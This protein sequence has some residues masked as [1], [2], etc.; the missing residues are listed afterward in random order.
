MTSWISLSSFL[1]ALITQPTFSPTPPLPPPLKTWMTLTWQLLS[2]SQ[3]NAIVTYLCRILCEGHQLVSWLSNYL[4][5]S[6]FHPAFL[7][8]FRLLSIFST[9]LLLSVFILKIRRIVFACKII[10]TIN[11]KPV[12]RSFPFPDDSK[13]SNDPGNSACIYL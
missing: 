6:F 7:L 5:P 9:F 3:N 8:L 10:T 2:P 11:D 1:T 13:Y 12:Y 4:F